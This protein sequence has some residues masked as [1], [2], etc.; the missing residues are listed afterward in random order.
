[1]TICVWSRSNHNLFRLC[2]IHMVLT[3]WGRDEMDNISQTTF[4][5]VFSSMKMFEFRLKFHWRLFPRVQ[6]TICQPWFRWWL[7][8]VQA[9]SHYLNQW[10]IVYRRI[11]ASLGLNELNRCVSTHLRMQCKITNT[12]PLVTWSAT[13]WNDSGKLRLIMCKTLEPCLGNPMVTGNVNGIWPLDRRELYISVG[14]MLK[15]SVSG[16]KVCIKININYGK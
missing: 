7:G 15:I 9:T 16:A 4:S 10:W 13:H 3:H 11:Y 12:H 5:N 1:M 14:L 2:W 6:F 8:A